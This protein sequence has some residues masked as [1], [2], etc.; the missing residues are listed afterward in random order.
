VFTVDDKMRKN[1]QYIWQYLGSKGWTINAVAA[2]LGNLQSESGMSPGIW[3]SATDYANPNLKPDGT[4]DLTYINEDEVK[5]IARALDRYKKNENGYYILDKYGNKILREP[6]HVGYGLVQW[7]PYTKL[8]SWC[9]DPRL[10]ETGSVLP[11]WDIDSQLDRIRWEAEKGEQWGLAWYNKGY[12]YEKESFDDLTFKSFIKSKK[13]AGWLAAAFAFCY[14][15]PGSSVPGVDDNGQDRRAVLC[16]TRSERGEFW[17]EYL[18]KLPPVTANKSLQIYDFTIDEKTYKNIKA[19]F[20]VTNGVSCKYSL[21]NSNNQEIA[22]GAFTDLQDGLKTIT[23]ENNPKIA[24]NAKYTLKLEITGD[25]NKKYYEK[26]SFTTLQD[27]PRMIKEIELK[28][29][30]DLK[31]ATSVFDL[32]VTMPDYL[33]YWKDN[34]GYYKQLFVNGRC[35]NTR[36]VNEVKN[37]SESFTIKEEFN[38]DCNIDDTVQ[39]GIT[40][41][42]KD[43][44]NKLLYNNNSQIAKVSKPIYLLSKPVQM[45]I[46][47][48]IS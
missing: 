37:L 47:D 22:S 40:V 29:K 45:F 9:K 15:K 43:A 11:F 4:I 3:E 1:A 14:E 33:G 38:Y 35:V 7:T 6:P 30:D 28:C 17:Y 12:K 2:L 39:I 5:E 16:K 41:W 42:V 32:K 21:V 25:T 20:I 26:I 8:I 19:S 44:E 34:C 36:T 27:Y 24:P 31:S 18:K 10:N 48:K 13:S 23:I 46:T